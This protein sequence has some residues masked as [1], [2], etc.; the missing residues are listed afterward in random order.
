MWDQTEGIE[1]RKLNYPLL[2]RNLPSQ[3]DTDEEY[4][5]AYSPAFHEDGLVIRISP[6]NY[7]ILY[8]PGTSDWF[9]QGVKQQKKG[10]AG[11]HEIKQSR[12]EGL[13]VLVDDKKKNE[14]L[15]DAT[16]GQA[17]IINKEFERWIKEGPEGV[18][19]DPA[20]VSATEEP[21]DEIMGEN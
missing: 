14:W 17:E 18:R 21:G 6:N 2:H 4:N 10:L 1:P 7:H 19:R 16:E 5:S 20:A 3:M 9:L 8:D 13:K 15:K 11:Y 12:R